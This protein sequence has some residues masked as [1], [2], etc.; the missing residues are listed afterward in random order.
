MIAHN[1]EIN[2]LRGNVNWLRAR[3]GAIFSPILGKDLDKVWPLIYDG[4][5]D[6]ASFDN[7][8]ELLT[9]SGYSLAHAMMLLIPEAWDADTITCLRACVMKPQHREWLP[10]ILKRLPTTLE[11]AIL[12]FLLAVEAH[13]EGLGQGTLGYGVRERTRRE[14]VVERVPELTEPRDA[15]VVRAEVGIEEHISRGNGVRAGARPRHGGPDVANEA[16][17]GR[18][19]DD[20]GVVPATG[21]DQR[22]VHGAELCDTAPLAH[23]GAV[24]TS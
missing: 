3:Q 1:G 4:Q 22:L 8:L 19:F 2:T 18:A 23:A 6:S 5:S 16:G 15:Q 9:M 13:V 21:D 12:A 7:A 10:E 24:H 11:L 14:P 17:G 20:E